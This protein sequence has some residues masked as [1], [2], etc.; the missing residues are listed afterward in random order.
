MYHAISL[1]SF[2]YVTWCDCVIRGHDPIVCVTTLPLRSTALQIM[3]H[4]LYR[5]SQIHTLQH[6]VTRC[7]TVYS[8]WLHRVYRFLH[9]CTLQ[10]AA[11][12][13]NALYSVCQHRVYRYSYFN[14]LLHTAT[15]CNARQHIVFSLFT[16]GTG[17]RR[18]IGC[19]KLQVIFR[20]R[21]TND[22]ALLRKMT[23]KDK[24]SYE[25]SPPCI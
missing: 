2:V 10:H 17:W 14:T 5:F 20:K 21:A 11:T 9:T 7:S 3:V 13:C 16:R 22:R 18:P 4:R 25:S 8:V 23:C 24:A 12:H 15:H 6:T 1:N 19:L